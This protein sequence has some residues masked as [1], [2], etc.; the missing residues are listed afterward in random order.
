MLGVIEDWFLWYW[1]AFF[2]NFGQ[3]ISETCTVVVFISNEN[4]H[5]ITEI[6][7]DFYSDSVYKSV[8]IKTLYRLFSAALF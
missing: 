5:F 3:V 1:E 2:I 4:T 7:L 8:I 6:D